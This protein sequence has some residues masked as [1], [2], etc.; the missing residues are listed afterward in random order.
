[1]PHYLIMYRPPRPTFATDASPS[2]AE[3]VSR[4]FAYLKQKLEESTLL[5]AGRRDDAEFG[6]AIIECADE[7]AAQEIVKNDPVVAAGVFSARVD[8][9]RLA[10]WRE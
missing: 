10:L 7:S 3:A 4:H 1:M 5:M 2:E 8:L 9:F 6:I